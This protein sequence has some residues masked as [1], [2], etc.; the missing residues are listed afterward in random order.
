MAMHHINQ[1]G[2]PRGKL[3]PGQCVPLLRMQQPAATVQ[4]E[5]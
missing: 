2:D 1:E 4:V 5:Q 3:S